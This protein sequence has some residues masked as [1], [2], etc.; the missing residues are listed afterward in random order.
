[1]RHKAEEYFAYQIIHKLIYEPIVV[2][3]LD[4]CSG[5]T[6]KVTSVRLIVIYSGAEGK[7]P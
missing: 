6:I 4:S 7:S 1:M 2:P 5:H 3:N